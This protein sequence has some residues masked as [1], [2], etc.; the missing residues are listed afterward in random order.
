MKPA[1]KYTFTCTAVEA[2][3]LLL[4]VA[5]LIATFKTRQLLESANRADE[6][7]TKL[8]AEKRQERR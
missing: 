6:L 3:M 8:L 7:L 5:S 2:R 4:G 1:K